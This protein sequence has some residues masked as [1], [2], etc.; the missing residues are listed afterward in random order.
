M[1]QVFHGRNTEIE[2]TL[3][4]LGCDLAQ[5]LLEFVLILY[6][7]MFLASDALDCI[8]KRVCFSSFPC[9][10]RQN[11]ELGESVCPINRGTCL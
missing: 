4:A 8:D 7:I 11:L 6:L 3:G 9:L 2:Q 1:W 10:R 5:D